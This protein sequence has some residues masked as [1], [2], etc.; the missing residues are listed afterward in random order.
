[1]IYYLRLQ[2]YSLIFY[3]F[4][5]ATAIS[6]PSGKLMSI[7]L[8]NKSNTTYTE[9][10]LAIPWKEVTSRYPTID[11]VQLRIVE[12]VSKKEL[13]YQLEYAGHRDVQNLLVEVNL[14][15]NSTLTIILQKLKPAAMVVK[16]Y[17]RYVPER[18]GDF[19]WENDRIA[20]R[21]YGKELESIPAE[22]AYGIDVWAKKT[23][24]MILN[25][26][27]KRGEYHIDH[28][29]GL[30]YY[31]V[32]Y[33]LGA[34]NSMPYI[35]DSIW[36]SR[37]YTQWNILDAGPLRFSFQLSYEPWNVA[38][39]QVAATKTITLD[40]G[41]QLNK[42]SVQYQFNG[43]SLPVVVGIIKRPQPG[44]EMLDEQ[45]GLLSYWEPQHGKDGTIGV[46]CL[47]LAPVKEMQVNGGQLLAFSQVYQGK[48]FVYYTGAAWDKAG[49][50]TNA[51]QW[52][53]YLQQYQH[54]T[55][56]DGIEIQYP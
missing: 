43:N 4:T 35:Q 26:R 9:K 18:K 34:G 41:S 8:R 39:Q 48:P 31:H 54:Q 42:I 17:G 45:Q 44:I 52:F 19:A 22:N 50:I 46:G 20:F 32:G 24:R 6:Q 7:T 14:R 51:Q 5:I 29:D 13:P 11:T 21:M 33:T 27:Y 3:C 36:Y 38:G 49:R 12:A 1:L 25:E 37:N 30:D 23:N 56:A 15:Q 2:S 28:G 47:L 10:I 16:T 55:E 53:A 40:A